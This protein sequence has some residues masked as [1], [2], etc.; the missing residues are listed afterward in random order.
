M[1]FLAAVCPKTWK[2]IDRK[3]GINRWPS[4]KIQKVRQS[5]EKLQSD[6][7]TVQGLSGTFQVGSV[8]SNFPELASPSSKSELTRQFSASKLSTIPKSLSVNAASRPAVSVLPASSC[9]HSLSSSHSC[10]SGSHTHNRASSWN[11]TRSEEVATVTGNDNDAAL[12]R[13]RS[14]THLRCIAC[15][16]PKSLSRSQSQVTFRRASNF[17]SLPPFAKNTRKESDIMRVKVTYGDEKIRIR[18]QNNWQFK[19][20]RKEIAR[21]FNASGGEMQLKYLDDDSE[22]VLLTCEADWQE[23][24]DVCMNYS[25]NI[26]KLSLYV[27]DRH[28]SSSINESGH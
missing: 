1:F 26:I 19:D 5:L 14:D 13:M 10:T 16:D 18:M 9:S 27:L 20:L 2:R 24:I 23:C 11:S 8:Y 21:R 22:W 25:S 4:R 28:G 6:I 17:E 12:K 15:K 3:Q 7:D